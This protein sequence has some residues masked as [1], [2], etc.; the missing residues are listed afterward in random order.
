MIL[1][2]KRVKEDDPGFVAMF[3][4][5]SPTEMKKKKFFWIRYSWLLDNVL[6]GFMISSWICE[7][8][9]KSEIELVA[10]V[11]GKIWISD[12]L[13]ERVTVFLESN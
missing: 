7:K 4:K 1:K 13:S 10:R 3:H 11:S 9:L 8:K 2:I 6:P 5:N 12:K